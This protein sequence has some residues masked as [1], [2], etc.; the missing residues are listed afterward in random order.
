MESVQEVGGE[1]GGGEKEVIGMT[2]GQTVFVLDETA[3]AKIN[4]L[5]T[6]VDQ[7]LEEV[8]TVKRKE[9]PEQFSPTYGLMRL[10]HVLEIIPV[11]ATTWWKWV[12]E[13]IAPQGK[14]LTRKLTVWRVEDVREFAERIG[15]KGLPQEAM[16]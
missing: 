1:N 5:E 2:S 9:E 6:K 7:L 3:A 15:N 8:K 12:R 11:S 14:Q 13:G 16:S 10:P 4:A